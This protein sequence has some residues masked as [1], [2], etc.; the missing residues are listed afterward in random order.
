M[1]LIIFLLLLFLGS[2]FAAVPSVTFSKAPESICLL[3]RISYLNSLIVDQANA[4]VDDLASA[5]TV[6]GANLR[7]LLSSQPSPSSL[8]WNATDNVN[9]K[10]EQLNKHNQTQ[11]H[12]AAFCP[13]CPFGADNGPDNADSQQ[14]KVMS[15]IIKSEKMI[16]SAIYDVVEIIER[17]TSVVIAQGNALSATLDTLI[18]FIGF[19]GS[20]LHYLYDRIHLQAMLSALSTPLFRNAGITK[21][22]SNIPRVLEVA[23]YINQSE[24]ISSESIKFYVLSKEAVDG[25]ASYGACQNKSI[26]YVPSTRKNHNNGKHIESSNLA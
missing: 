14:N 13:G 3:N 12:V 4:C 15:D 21:F 20:S 2:V 10:G 24:I 19:K 11:F 1:R 7:R 22:L 23:R 5:S 17:L 9:H 6:S 25:S 16:V 18:R 8:P 26:A